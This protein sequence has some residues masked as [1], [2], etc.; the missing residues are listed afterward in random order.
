MRATKQYL[1]FNSR[2]FLGCALMPVIPPPSSFPVQHYTVRK[3][4]VR[5]GSVDTHTCVTFL[6][7]LKMYLSLIFSSPGPHLIIGNQPMDISADPKS[8]IP[9][10]LPD[11]MTSDQYY[12]GTLIQDQNRVILMNSAGSPMKT[13]SYYIGA[14]D[15]EELPPWLVQ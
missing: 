11:S 3:E 14:S 4:S 10:T 12:Y 7:K 6:S 15:T 8:S 5:V 9:L 1:W 2:L 13:L